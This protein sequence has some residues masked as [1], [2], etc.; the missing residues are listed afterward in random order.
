M[1]YTCMYSLNRIV[2]YAM[3]T[4]IFSLTIKAVYVTRTKKGVGRKG[5]VGG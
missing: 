1:P 3:F 5:G 4:S 2:L